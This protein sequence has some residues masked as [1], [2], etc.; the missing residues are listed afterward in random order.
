MILAEHGKT[1][2]QIAQYVGVALSTLSLWKKTVGGEFSE[3]LKECK[4]IADDLVEASLLN[5]ALGYRT[6]EVKVFCYEGNIIEHEVVK[7]YAPSD[8]AMIF[9]LK[10]RRPDKW[11]DRVEIAQKEYTDMEFKDRGYENG[12]TSET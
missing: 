7:E 2:E 1:D 4:N 12:S 9:W 8:T 11:R 3:A 5:R 6:K 10:N